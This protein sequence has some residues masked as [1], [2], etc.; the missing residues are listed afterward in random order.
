MIDTSV[1]FDRFDVP[2]THYTT[3]P[4]IASAD[5]AKLNAEP[6]S[7]DLYRRQVKEGQQYD[8][9]YQMWLFDLFEH[10]KRTPGT[11]RLPVAWAALLE[12]LLSR[13]FTQW[14]SDGLHLDLAACRLT[15]GLYRYGDRDYTTVSTA[16]L[17]KAMHWAL[18][19]NEDWSSEYGGKLNLWEAK[20][21]EEPA[22]SIL[23]AGGT[24]AMFAPT[25]RTWHNIGKVTTGGE[26]ERLTIMLEYWKD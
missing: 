17:T 24:C 13:D 18:Y 23:P 25:E 8:K 11:E 26:V 1:E 14:A 12:S 5:L 19:L 20:D 15:L 3:G 2:F 6:P 10:G 22:V 9:N 21:A 7:A 4:V 16:K